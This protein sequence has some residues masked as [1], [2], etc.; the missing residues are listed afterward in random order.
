MKKKIA[1]ILVFC[2]AI[3]SAVFASDAQITGARAIVEGNTI[4]V[5]G[6]ISTGEGKKVSVKV[7]D[8]N[9]KLIYLNDALAGKDGAFGFQ[10]PIL[11][12]ISGE[13]RVEL[14]GYGVEE[15]VQTSVSYVVSAE[16]EFLSFSLDG[17]RGTIN[18]T[19]VTV[20]CYNVTNYNMTA[21]FAAS[22]KATV[23]VGDKVQESG[24]TQNNF[25]NSV[26]YTVVAEDGSTKNY[27]VS[28][29]VRTS[30]GS[31][32][33]GGGGG[34]GGGNHSVP[35]IDA[36]IPKEEEPQPEPK[37]GF[38]DLDSVPWAVEYIEKLAEKNILNGI[39][40]TSFAPEQYITREEFVKLMAG[41]FGLAP[42]AGSLPFTDVREDA[43]YYGY[44]CG[45]V[46]HGI[47]SGTSENTFG[48]GEY[49]TRQDMAV[50]ACRAAAVAGK[51]LPGGT[52][53]FTDR[54][55]IADYALESVGQMNGAGIIQGMGD[56]RFAPNEYATRAQAAKIA[57]LLL[58][59]E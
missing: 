4:S 59:M 48:V 3:A 38:D 26:I 14:G 16:K 41:V 35:S 15:T 28:L 8:P 58:E 9:G 43:W 11:N 2:M 1:M 52:T 54:E 53:E 47:I 51:Q 37:T 5:T 57:C 19:S 7:N 27:T 13:Y 25:S 50:I 56:G 33:S 29:D 22:P 45:A 31:G 10:V 36:T 40:E 21:S 6:V 39:S 49:V 30:G 46:K 34:G 23:R 44:R 17:N 24:V 32:S 12:R 42:E 18:G 55:R 20:T